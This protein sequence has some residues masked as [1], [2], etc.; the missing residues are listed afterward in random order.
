MTF[1]ELISALQKRFPLA[2]GQDVAELRETIKH[3]QADVQTDAA[4]VA[5]LFEMRA[6]LR[7]REHASSPQQRLANPRLR[8]TYPNERKRAL[9][10]RM[11]DN[12]DE[13]AK[14]L[15]PAVD[16]IT[17]LELAKIELELEDRRDRIFKDAE[18][19]R[20]QVGIYDELIAAIQRL[21][22]QYDVT[23]WHWQSLTDEQLRDIAAILWRREKEDLPIKTRD[24][25][26]RKRDT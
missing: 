7:E 11:L 25:W 10:K 6:G 15:G 24:E 20:K 12:A 9:T 1:D 13:I 18:D 8:T 16:A 23:R 14:H 19:I 17:R 21:Y 22:E 5:S 3:H 2:F 4:Y 26:D